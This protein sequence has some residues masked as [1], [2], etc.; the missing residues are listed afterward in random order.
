MSDYDSCVVR[1]LLEYLYGAVFSVDTLTDSRQLGQLSQMA[2]CFQL[3]PLQECLRC[4]EITE[5]EEEEDVEDEAQGAK[6]EGFF[7]TVDHK[8]AEDEEEEKLPYSATQNLDA[9]DR[10]LDDEDE[11]EV[12]TGTDTGGDVQKLDPADDWDE[13]CVALTQKARETSDNS[14]DED[15]EGSDDSGDNDLVKSFSPLPTSPVDLDLQ[16]LPGSHSLREAS[17]LECDDI[18]D[19]KSPAETGRCSGVTRASPSEGPA[20]HRQGRQ[21]RREFVHILA[22]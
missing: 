14:E 21:L 13:V 4:V 2:R 18:T 5:V 10:L 17:P 3:A 6:S 22:T 7:H 16:L 1:V 15:G 8:N 12:E 9:L 19:L 11:E 20:R